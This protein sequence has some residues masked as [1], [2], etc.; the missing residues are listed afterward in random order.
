MISSRFIVLASAL[1]LCHPTPGRAQAAAGPALELLGLSP[2]G[3]QADLETQVAA[4]GGKLSCKQ[5][6]V[7]RRFAECKA[8]LT[9]T[10]DGRRWAALAS[11]VEGTTAIILLTATLDEPALARLR[12]DLTNSLGRPNLKTRGK[13][14]TYE[15]VR[16]G[17]MLRLASRREGGH[18]AVGV[19][20]I[21]GKVLDQLN[22]R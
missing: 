12:Q 14:E 6:G 15:W 9:R 13:D 21:E 19:S 16:R 2:G 3:T 20:L 11:V 4:L 10:P 18:L 7:D 17:R 1:T 8:S 22:N 5:S